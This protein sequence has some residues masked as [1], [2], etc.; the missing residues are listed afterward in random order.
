MRESYPLGR[1]AGLDLSA[2]PSALVAG[3]GLWALGSL[4]ARAFGVSARAVPLVGLAVAALHWAGELWHQYGHAAVAYRTGYP[5][6]GIQLWGPLSASQYPAEPDLPPA[7]HIRRALGGPFA[8]AL[9]VAILAGVAQLVPRRSVAG[10]LV[11]FA[12]WENLL[13]FCLGA[14]LPLGFN[15]GSSLLHWWGKRNA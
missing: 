6:T 8:S 13:V 4:G 7:T 12:F 14:F 3:A 1:V 15:D 10:K 5:M 9:L 11:R 2:R